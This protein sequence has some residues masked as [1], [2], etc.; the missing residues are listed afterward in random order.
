M[1]T[2]GVLV[3]DALGLAMALLILNLVRTQMLHVGYAVLWLSA[4]GSLVLMVSVPGLQ[5]WIPGLVGAV[6]PASA[7]AL[8]AFVFTFL[9][10][11]FFSVKLSRLSARHAEL[12]QRLG[13]EAAAREPGA[14]TRRE[15]ER[16]PGTAADRPG[17]KAEGEEG[18]PVPPAAQEGS[19]AVGDGD[20]PDPA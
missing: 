4:I 14:A 7:L 20:A 12:V 3:I 19:G 11:I 15:A 9:V 10:L 2:Q 8:L 6:Y 5:R 17:T 1:S 18:T 16:E 13:L